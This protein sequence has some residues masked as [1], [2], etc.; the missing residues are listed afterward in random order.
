MKISRII[1]LCLCLL[2]V[3]SVGYCEELTQEKINAIKELMSI[4]G[5]TQ[6]AEILGKAVFQRM[7]NF[8]QKT[9]PEIDLRALKIMEEEVTSLMREETGEKGSFQQLIFPIYNKYL[10]LDEIREMI[11]FYKTPAGK[12]MTSVLPKMMQELMQASQPWANSLV[13]RIQQRVLTRFEKEGIKIRGLAY[14]EKGQCDEAISNYTKA[15]EIN[16]RDAEAYYN[17]GIAYDNKGQYDQAISDYTKALEI[18]PRDAEAYYNRGI[19]Y[20]RKSQ[21]DEAI[22]DFSKALKIDPR[23]AGAY[24]NRGIAYNK[25]VQYDQA[26]SDFNKALE[27]NPRFAEAYRSRGSTY[28]D[29]G[30]YD[31]AISDYN[32]ALEIDPRDAEAYYN[33]GIAYDNKGQYDQAI[34]DY[35]KALEI[36]PRDAWTYYNRGV[37]YGK[38]GQ[39]D[40]AISDYSKTLEKNPKCADAYNNLA[41]LL[42]TANVTR[43]RNGEKALQLALKACELTDWK[44]PSCLDTLAAAYARLGDFVNAIK[45]QEKAL[46][47]PKLSNNKD[48]QQR[49]VLYREHKPWPSD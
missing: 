4:T 35:T 6:V 18:N 8:V 21:Y 49:L 12:K 46:E 39:Y 19:V 27:I 10:T 42:A 41:W 32:K 23:H 44:N 15:L 25:K 30:Q 38:K 20:N 7:A 13:P 45:W 26:V 40:Q 34:S 31:D 11:R 22:S 43:F 28:D 47:S 33:R 36:D 29:K 3:A 48:A 16:P 24:Y 17:R 1:A 14:E 37:A 5:S 9:N 2:I